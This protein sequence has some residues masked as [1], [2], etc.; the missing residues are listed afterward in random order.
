MAPNREADSDTAFLKE[1]VRSVSLVHG[2]CAFGWIGQF[3]PL[4]AAVILADCETFYYTISDCYDKEPRQ[5]QIWQ[6]G[7]D[8]FARILFRIKIEA[9]SFGLKEQMIK[10]SMP[11]FVKFLTGWL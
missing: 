1:I 10:N 6:S 9:F 11:V 7:A 4:L 8:Q 3:R 5:K 2:R